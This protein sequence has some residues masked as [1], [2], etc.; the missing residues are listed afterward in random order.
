[1]R[2]MDP[3]T[4]AELIAFHNR[5]LEAERAGVQVLTDLSSKV[6]DPDLNPVLMRFL[7]DEGMNCQILTTLIRNADGQPSSKVGDFVEKVRALPTTEEKLQLLIRGQE[8]VAK[9]IRRNRELPSKTS[10]RMFMES[11]KIQHEENVDTLTSYTSGEA[12]SPRP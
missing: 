2:E 9:H 1:M 12:R 11:M 6:K 8:W 5:L 10:D 4:K 7:R 3:N